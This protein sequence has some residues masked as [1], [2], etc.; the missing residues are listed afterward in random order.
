MSSATDKT[1]RRT[2]PMRAGHLSLAF[3]AFAACA[4]PSIGT[5]TT[6]P[7]E[8]SR[9]GASSA[10]LPDCRAYELATPAL[11]SPRPELARRRS[12]GHHSPM[13][14]RSPSSAA[15]CRS[16]PKAPPR[17]PTR[18]SPAAGPAAGRRRAS[19]RATP[20]ASATFYGTLASTVGLSEDLT[21][22]V[23]WT[24]QPLAGRR[25][26]RRRE[27]LPAPRRRHHRSR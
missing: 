8:S 14:P 1:D 18:S 4:A 23:L 9:P 20:L 27:S 2:A 21:Q 25:L 11:N 13:V 22:S 17:P 5:A 12:S 16:K 10:T 15:A 24:D 7:N 3:A 26:S 19:R 6:C